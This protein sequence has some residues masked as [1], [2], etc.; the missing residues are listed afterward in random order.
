MDGR[1][2]QFYEFG[3]FRID[4]AERMLTRDGVRVH[5]T[6]KAFEVLL[7]LVENHGHVVEK[8]ALMSGLWPDT[9]VEEANVTQNVFAVR[10][11][12]GAE[13]GGRHYIETVSRRGYRFVA[14]VREGRSEDAADVRAGSVPASGGRQA[15]EV[16]RSIAVLPILNVGEA[17]DLEYLSDGITENIILNLS[18]L[19][20]LR[21]MARSTVFRYKGRE[22]D[23]R[24]VGR[25]LNVEMALVGR[26]R[27]Y[28][29]RLLLGV[30]MVNAADGSQIW[31]ES[32]NR[33]RSDVFRVQDEISSELSE[34]LR[35]ELTSEERK[36]LIRRHTKNPE[37]YLLYLKGLHFWYKRTVNDI[38][39]SI[40]YFE[41]A[42]GLDADYA[43]AHVGLADC[44]ISLTLINALSFKE[45]SP[46]VRR[47]LAE[48]LVLDE[49]LD[50]AHASLAYIEMLALNWAES[51]REFRLAI[52]LNPNNALT[53]SR[54]ALYL[55]VWGQMERAQEE[56][57]L[58]LSLDPLSPPVRV[59]SAMLLYYAGQYE[60]SIEQCHQAL[61]I[62]PNFS[63]AY[64]FLSVVYE[65]LGK[66]QDA[67]SE[68]RKVLGLLGDDPEAL[69]FLGYLYAVSGKRR[70]AKRVLKKVVK[71][72]EQ[73]YAPPCCLA[74]LHAI[75]GDR[76]EAFRWLEKALQERSNLPVLAISPLFN[77]LHSDPRFAD[78]LHHIGL[79]H[80]LS[81]A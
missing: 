72:S 51:E 41:G 14:D 23:V 48:A 12:L 45:A 32:Y 33:P 35:I 49:T 20:M 34:Q 63:E 4:V 37:A 52:E 77:C 66:Y 2:S 28:K 69:S 74:W 10:K 65:R 30:E 59:Q 42:L 79:P 68:I 60:R 71:L 25:E 13:G 44:Y 1:T 62:E 11:V 18:R 24:Q 53:H 67:M 39:R 3:P 7:M 40:K 76:D 64:G 27:E 9:C 58:A 19:P 36:R 16:T 61:E 47:D 55:A 5:L 50:G 26:L 31:G 22:P 56:V 78:L 43:L 17:P 21:V 54:Y 6:P 80:R 15:G 38:K 46:M 29:G 57:E 75:L 81:Y 70:E 73:K 8:D